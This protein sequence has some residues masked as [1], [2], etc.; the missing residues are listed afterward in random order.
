MKA[1]EERT[2]GGYSPSPGVIYP[3]LSWLE[4]MGYAGV[5]SGDG[6]R[7]FRITP[8]GEAFL[9]ANRAALEALSER[10]GGRGASGAA[11]AMARRSRCCGRWT[12]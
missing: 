2:G 5:A 6:R 11:G 9:V 4:D 3:T 12:R 7:T 1:I 8:E 10:L